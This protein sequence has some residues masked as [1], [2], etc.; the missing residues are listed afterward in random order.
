MESTTQP[1]ES[2]TQPTEST[3]QPMS[4][5][6]QPKDFKHLA[7]NASLVIDKMNLPDQTLVVSDYGDK[8]ERTFKMRV[9]EYKFTQ[10]KLY[11]LGTCDVSSDYREYRLDGLI[12]R[13]QDW[14]R[15]FI[16]EWLE[17]WSAN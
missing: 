17:F 16:Q 13:N 2:T 5:V 10:E 6:P 1:T 15:D 8:T 14:F 7:R 11:F 3:T 12:A 9:L 4:Q